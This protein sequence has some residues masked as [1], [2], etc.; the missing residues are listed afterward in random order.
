LPIQILLHPG[1][2]RWGCCSPRAWRGLKRRQTVG[3]VTNQTM[4]TDEQFVAPKAAAGGA[5]TEGP[6]VRELKVAGDASATL[7]KSICK[8][9]GKRVGKDVVER[10]FCDGTISYLDREELRIRFPTSLH[11]TWAETYY[12]T[13]LERVVEEQMAAKPKVTLEAP[14]EVEG[15]LRFEEEEPAGPEASVV[16]EGAEVNR[17]GSLVPETTPASRIN[18]ARLN[19]KHTFENFVVGD[20]IAYC[21]AA[22]VAVAERPG[23]H[24]NPVLFYGNSGLG[25]THLLSAI[26]L[27]VLQRHPR[28][29]VLFVTGEEFTNEFIEAV[30]HGK[31]SQ[32]RARYRRVDVLLIDDVQFVAGKDATQEEFFHTF[33]ALVNHRSQIVLVS[34]RAPADIPRLEKRLLSRFQWG[35][36]AE[37]LPPSVET[38]I[39]IL[40]QKAHEWRVEIGMEVIEFLADRIRKNVRMLEGALLR[41]SSYVSLYRGAISLQQVESQLQDML[42]QEAR[43]GM[44]TVGAIQKEVAS[45]FDVRLGDLNGRSRTQ[46]IIQP[47]HIAMYLSRELTNASLK[48]IGQAFG[49]R[50]HGTVIHACRRVD[51]EMVAGGETRRVVE[52]LRDKITG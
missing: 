44:V 12:R 32:F 37:L 27:S 33:N 11:V 30:Q 28:K 45:Y 31:L 20:N 51:E 35:I 29:R 39:A 43:G 19:P 3:G 38:R 22:A 18:E 16:E 48:D 46:L 26:G 34:D 21:H 24:Y 47:R 52:F 40:R 4:K 25:K 41:V 14:T 15:N 7:W 5:V 23:G 13:D 49:G 2:I 42:C 36:S 9:L 17:V 6:R 10:W 50:D 8:G 1:E